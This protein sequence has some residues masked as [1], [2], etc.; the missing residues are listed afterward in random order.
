MGGGRL[1]VGVDYGWRG[2]LWMARSA[3]YAGVDHGWEGRLWMRIDYAEKRV[4]YGWVGWLWMIRSNFIWMSIRSF[5]NLNEVRPKRL[6]FCGIKELFPYKLNFIHILDDFFRKC[7]RVCF[8]LLTPFDF[9]DFFVNV[10]HFNIG[11]DQTH[12][13]T[14]FSLFYVTFAIGKCKSIYKYYNRWNQRQMWL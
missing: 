7:F 1:W 2:R 3:K 14:Q 8:G 5:L 4:D 11:K 10:Q 6:A 12:T 9:I 13:K